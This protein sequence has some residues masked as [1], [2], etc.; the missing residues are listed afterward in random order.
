MT[1]YWH[2][3]NPAAAQAIQRDG[4]IQPYGYGDVLPC[5][6]L[7]E[8]AWISD[9]PCEHTHPWTPPVVWLME[10]GVPVPWNHDGPIVRFTVEAPDA[11]RWADY[12]REHGAPDDWITAKP[13]RD[14]P[15][16]PNPQRFQWITTTPV[17]R[18]QWRAVQ[19]MPVRRMPVRL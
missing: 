14:A 10:T 6:T 5:V 8:R 7:R 17:P 16:H 1:L 12:A 15:H 18:S 19:W 11:Q 2:F 3:T 4:V 13:S 9:T